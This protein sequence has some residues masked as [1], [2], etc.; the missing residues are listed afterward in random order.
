MSSN[1]RPRGV[2]RRT[3]FQ[4]G[5]LGASAVALAQSTSIAAPRPHTSRPNILFLIADQHRADCVGAD[6]NA[7]IH[8]PNMDRLAREGALFRCAYSTTPTCTPARAALLTGMN[9]WNHGML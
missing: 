2:S 3:F 5:A 4:A 1:S 9:P 7:A 6:G 8:T